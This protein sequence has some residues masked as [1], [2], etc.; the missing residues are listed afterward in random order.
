MYIVT[1]PQKI[2]GSG[3]EHRKPRTSQMSRTITDQPVVPLKAGTK[4]P[5]LATWQKLSAS[6]LG[7]YGKR[8]KTK[9]WS[10]RCDN[11]VVVDVDAKPA[12]ADKACID[13]ASFRDQIFA[14]DTYVV[15][16][17]S[18]NPHAYFVLDEA[19]MA[20]WRKRCGIYGFVDV[21]IGNNSLVVSAGSIVDGAKYIVHRNRDISS[22]PD[23]LF[24]RLDMEMRRTTM[25]HKH[26]KDACM[27][28]NQPNASVKMTES[29][30]NLEQLLKRHG[31][32]APVLSPNSYQGY[33][34][35]FGYPHTCPI[36]G[37]HHDQIDGFLFTTSTNSIMA[38]CYSERCRGR[39]RCLSS[40][41]ETYKQSPELVE[42]IDQAADKGQHYSITLVAAHLYKD[43]MKYVGSEGWFFFDRS[44][45]L[46]KQDRHGDRMRILL[47]TTVSDEF[48]RRIM[49]LNEKQREESATSNDNE[50]Y[51]ERYRKLNAIMSKLGDGY[52]KD[53]LIKEAQAIMRDDKFMDTLDDGRLLGFDDGVFDFQIMSFR[54]GQ[55]EDRVSLSVGY[56]FPRAEDV[57]PGVIDEVRQV[58]QDPFES[59]KMT[60]YVLQSLAACMDG[61]R[62]V[63]E[64]FVW[65]GA[66]SNGKSTIEE[67]VMATMGPYAQSLDISFWTR[68]KGSAGSALPELA[69]KRACR[70][71]FSNEPEATDKL[72][73]AKIKEATGGE[74]LTARKL[75]CDPITYRPKFGIFFLAN[76]LPELSKI[77][78]GISR[79]IRVVPFIHQF[80][81]FPL[82]GQRLARPSVME[83]CRLNIQWR[84]ALMRILIDMYASVASL[85]AIPYPQEVQHASEEYLEDNN[86]VGRFLAD[87]Y[88]ITGVDADF[89]RAS[90][91]YQDYIDSTKDRSM[92]VTAFGTAMT[93]INH[94]PKKKKRVEGI[95]VCCYL[96][97]VQN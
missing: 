71:I 6:E 1:K 3:V 95:S 22:M 5:I 50:V 20:H 23:W 64:F 80:K 28:F 48:A 26:R 30:T 24:D 47:S 55:P 72:Q 4:I 32:D 58:F 25:E 8:D 94:V 42:L 75:Y 56:K 87:H 37:H 85:T 78:G 90:E 16:T 79:R 45:G 57:D 44:N 35:V 36:T 60:N 69:D 34:I 10:I 91:L 33:D 61:R 76:T 82:P 41:R 12:N 63:A 73:V 62:N 77:D 67:L 68:P 52:H 86:P 15:K 81:Q 74:K 18:G 59:E 27:E 51:E 9:N 84:Q 40:S 93:Q 31:Y 43:T 89:I 11:I 97:I 14:T 49:C 54:I 38:G 19:R 13:M 66:G 65:T 39:Y 2:S 53:K 92:T 17:R 83:N 96:G 29:P 7:T 88:T 46:W 21:C 70:Y